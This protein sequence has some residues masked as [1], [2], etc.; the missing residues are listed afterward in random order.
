[1]KR[2]KMKPFRSGSSIW[3]IL[4]ILML[5][6][7]LMTFLFL[8]SEPESR[9]KAERM[10]DVPMHSDRQAN[11]RADVIRK[12]LPPLKIELIRQVINTGK[13][14][15]FTVEGEFRQIVKGLG[16]SVPSVTPA[17][18]LLG[19]TET[20]VT[21]IA[22]TTQVPV[23][24]TP[25]PTMTITPSPTG[26]PTTWLPPAA[27]R[28]PES[29]EPSRTPRPTDPPT[30]TSMPLNTLV[31]TSTTAPTDPPAPTEPPVEVTPVQPTLQPT[32]AATQTPHEVQPTKKP[33]PKPTKTPK[34]PDD[35][36]V[37]NLLMYLQHPYLSVFITTE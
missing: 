7:S 18:G 33:K 27:T 29:G 9:V 13:G 15:S 34:S 19:P 11:Y 10:I 6:V 36:I 26:T 8:L 28:T 31:P 1:M 25:S 12:F 20:Q 35:N 4:L 16:S 17:N 22:A 30:A 37:L 3:Q 14:P 2:P 24:P 23:T 21:L 5:S 32:A